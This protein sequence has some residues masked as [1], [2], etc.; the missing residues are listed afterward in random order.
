MHTITIIITEGNSINSFK[1][2]YDLMQTDVKAGLGITR[3]TPFAWRM[4]KRK[5]FYGIG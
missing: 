4:L 2:I 3:K 1:P 5:A